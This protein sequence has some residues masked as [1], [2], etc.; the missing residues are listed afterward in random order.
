M[1]EEPKGPSKIERKSSIQN[2]QSPSDLMRTP[3]KGSTKSSTKQYLGGELTPK[4]RSLERKQVSDPTLLPQPSR[5]GSALKSEKRRWSMAEF[6]D[7]SPD[8]ERTAVFGGKNFR[9]TED[10][11][12]SQ[13]S[14]VTSSSFTAKP[15]APSNKNSTVWFAD[16]QAPAKNKSASKLRA[17]LAA[18]SQPT[19]TSYLPS[20]TALSKSQLNVA[21]QEPPKETHFREIPIHTKRSSSNASDKKQLDYSRQHKANAVPEYSFRPQ[22]SAKSMRMAQNMVIM[23]NDFRKNLHL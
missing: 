17:S 7:K 11:R 16:Q 15:P 22:L 10:S 19:L 4:R 18:P 9:P 6:E 20:Q 13:R 1:Q 5:M 12:K 8:K 3:T 23:E 21:W 14:F 2:Y